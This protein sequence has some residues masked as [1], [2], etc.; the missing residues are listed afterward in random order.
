MPRVEL[1]DE[2]IDRA[3]DKIK[4]K[5]REKLREKGRHSLCST[6]ECLGIINEEHAELIE[7]VRSNSDEEFEEEMADIGICV[8]LALASLYADGLEW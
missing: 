1:T 5:F 2:I 7:A 3:F 4:H 6:H 8:I